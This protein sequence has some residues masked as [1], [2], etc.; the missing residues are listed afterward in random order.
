MLRIVS[1]GGLS[2]QA[3]NLPR[4]K[5]CETGQNDTHYTDKPTI[6]QAFD[7]AG[8]PPPIVSWESETH[9]AKYK[10]FQQFEDICNTLSGGEAAIPEDALDLSRFGSMQDWLVLSKPVKD[11]DKFQYAYFGKGLTQ[12]LGQDLSKKCTD[13]YPDHVDRFISAI[14][15]D[16][17][18]RK[19][20]VTTAH[21]TAGQLFVS[22]WWRS[23]VPV[24]NQHGETV[25]LLAHNYP[26]NEL[27]AGLEIIPVPVLI[28]DDDHRVC[29]SNKAARQKFDQGRY[30]PWDRALF[31][32]AGLDLHIRDN[33][34]DIL[35]SGLTQTTSC[36][37]I[38]YQR[39][40][41]YQATVSATLYRER[42]FFVVLLQQLD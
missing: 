28:L 29:Y 36:R 1:S 24:C 2:L 42:A 40:G 16:V 15:R 10:T 12:V 6:E 26:E 3:S 21:H 18:T 5:S 33:P 38:M 17:M 25:G 19:R 9:R 41:K 39:L 34:E 27:R 13:E 37:H 11:G 32:Y 14:N 35:A 4:S 8:S 7:A 22:L 20:R 23:I 31:D 30:G